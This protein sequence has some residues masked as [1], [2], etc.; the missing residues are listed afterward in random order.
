MPHNVGTAS[1]LLLR[2]LLEFPLYRTQWVSRAER[3]PEPDK[4]SYQA[5]SRVIAEW[6]W[7]TGE[8]SETIPPRSLRDRVRRA[9][10]GEALTPETLRWFVQAFAM[11]QRHV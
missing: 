10:I 4:I 9:L 5:V 3:L 8:I 11:E 1:R 7:A 2:L 6:T